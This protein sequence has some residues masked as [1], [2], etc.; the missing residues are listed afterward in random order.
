[1]H[2]GYINDLSVRLTTLR[3]QMYSTSSTN[4]YFCQY[5]Q[6][7]DDIRIITEYNIIGIILDSYF[8]NLTIYLHIFLYSV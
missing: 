2:L 1:M 4:T 6:V 5:K 3:Q 7:Y 8:I